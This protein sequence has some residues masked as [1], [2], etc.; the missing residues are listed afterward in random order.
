MSC[1]QRSR[2]VVSMEGSI[3]N[4]TSADVA[5]LAGV[6]RATVSYVLNGRSDER[7]RPQTR[8]RV[9]A[10]V[11]ELGYAPNA[12]ARTLRT[13]RSNTVLMPTIQLPGSPP[14][15]TFIEQLAFALAEQ[16]LCLLMHGGRRHTGLEAAQEWAALRPVAV[17][18][19]PHQCP[20]ESVEFLQRAGVRAVV[21]LGAQASE[22]G[23]AIALPVDHSAVART[24]A[25]YL[26]DRGCRRL[27]CLVPTGALAVL[28]IPRLE[29]VSLVA[30]PAG[31][32]VERVDCDLTEQSITPTVNRWRTDPASRPDGIYA[33]ND[34]HALL[35]IEALRE[36]G[37]RTPDDIAVVGSGNFPM[38]RILRPRLTTTYVPAER[39]ATAIATTIANAL[40][41]ATGTTVPAPPPPELIVRESA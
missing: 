18:A 7:V 32:P 21:L 25:E 30:N 23:S 9:L 36:A 2:R 8:D 27:A 19:N 14:L 3:N 37:L 24:A 17:I 12:T 34:E 5:R 33:Y 38:G 40:N 41:G 22:A 13:G 1:R 6:S 16:D 20:P 35:L 31:I 28:G 10:A 4:P 11:R 26:I 15:D 29:A 39:H